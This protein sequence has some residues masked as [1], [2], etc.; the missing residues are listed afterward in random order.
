MRLVRFGF[1]L[2]YHPLAFTYDAVSWLVSLG[3]W[4][5]WQRGGMLRLLADGRVLDLAHGTGNLQLDLANA[6][7]WAAGA[8]FSRQM[9]AI[10]R[11]K[12]MTAGRPV[13][14]VRSRAQALPFADGSFSGIISTFPTDFIVA[15][16]T[17]RE[18]WRVLAA[19][20]VL[21]VVPAA[22]FTGRGILQRTLEWA[23]RVTGQQTGQANDASLKA[24]VLQLAAQHFVP[25]GFAVTVDAH[26]LAKSTAVVLIARKMP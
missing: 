14:L 24:Q 10:A 15:P 16:E 3:A 4:R 22:V 26:R 13:R 17:L 19:D 1:W 5:E 23:Y 12:L 20:G 21:V 9:G 2:L 25:V 6:G 7:R 8:D 11:R 18:C